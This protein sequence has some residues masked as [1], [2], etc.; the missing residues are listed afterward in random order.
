MDWQRLDAV[1]LLALLELSKGVE[2]RLVRLHGRA[3]QNQ[4]CGTSCHDPED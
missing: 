1:D 2:A 3:A 4:S